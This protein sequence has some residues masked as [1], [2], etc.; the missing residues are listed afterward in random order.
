MQNLLTSI[1]TPP[2][3]QAPLIQNPSLRTVCSKKW[4]N[5]LGK[6]TDLISV[7]RGTVSSTP[8]TR[9][10]VSHINNLSTQNAT[11][12]EQQSAV[13]EWINRSMVHIR[14]MVEERVQSG[15][16]TETNTQSLL[17]ANAWVVALMSR[18]KVQ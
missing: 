5:R 6:V 3:H 15:H 8:F 9:Q 18:F 1:T 4:V 2:R 16:A 7:L 11:A 13:T 17:N 14:H 12:A 10:P